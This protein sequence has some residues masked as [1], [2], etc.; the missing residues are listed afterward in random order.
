MTIE[1]YTDEKFNWP[2]VGIDP[3]F[4]FHM[5]AARTFALA[6]KTLA[7]AQDECERRWPIADRIVICVQREKICSGNAY[8]WSLYGDPS[9]GPMGG[10]R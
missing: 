4:T 3:E 7:E 5:G 1:N 8:G 9:R 6:A 10:A 2:A